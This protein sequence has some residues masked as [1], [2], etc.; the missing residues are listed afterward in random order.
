MKE[1]AEAR[2]HVMELKDT[3]PKGA[4]KLNKEI[5]PR[6]QNEYFALQRTSK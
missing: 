2:K 1:W 6:F 3:D 5:T 4:E